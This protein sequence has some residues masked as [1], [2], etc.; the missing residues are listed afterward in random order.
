MSV[1]WKQSL[2]LNN[3]NVTNNYMYKKILGGIQINITKLKESDR[4]K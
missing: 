2:A 1:T 3:E 4:V